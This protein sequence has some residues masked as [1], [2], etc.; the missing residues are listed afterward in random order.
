MATFDGEFPKGV[1]GP[2]VYKKI[3]GMRLVKT[4]VQHAMRWS[5]DHQT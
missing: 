3:C 5:F 2:A 4:I 1:M